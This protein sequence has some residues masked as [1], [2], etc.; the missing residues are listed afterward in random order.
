M[1]T[2]IRPLVD[3]GVYLS[4]RMFP[5][6]VQETVWTNSTGTFM[7]RPS[8]DTDVFI[9]PNCAR[10][11]IGGNFEATFYNGTY[12]MAST[13]AS[14]VCVIAFDEYLHPT[15][16][17]TIQSYDI[18][19]DVGVSGPY[20]ATLYV[21][22]YTASNVTYYIEICRLNNLNNCTK[23]VYGNWELGNILNG[24]IIISYNTTRKGTLL[25]IFS[26]IF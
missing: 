25:F 3:G 1:L 16:V 4:N 20:I 18:A 17:D 7:S 12:Y 26:L 19:I 6:I 23:L 14:N 5:F 9:S 8:T 24:N 11:A 22:F 13:C 10:C 2:I 15:Q 21:Q